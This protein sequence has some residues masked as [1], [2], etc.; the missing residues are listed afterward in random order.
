MF[1]SVIVFARRTNGSSI[2]AAKRV[3]REAK[4]IVHLVDER[5]DGTLFARSGP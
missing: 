2:N 3:R 1:R 4:Q 5:M